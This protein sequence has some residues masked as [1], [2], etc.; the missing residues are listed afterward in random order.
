MTP[1]KV[2]PHCQ[3]PANLKANQCI[4]CGHQ[5]RTPFVPRHDQTQ[6]YNLPNPLPAP[7]PSQITAYRTEQSNPFLI[8]LMWLFVVASVA[9]WI[10][11]RNA[12]IAANIGA[13]MT[14]VFLAV[15]PSSANRSS[16]WIMLALQ[17][18]II[19]MVLGGILKL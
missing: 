10:P 17:S 13:I 7:V 5:F 14:A 1:Y 2:C 9:A 15:S 11:L 8:A 18:V 19:L 12:G 16:G 4:Q 3:H 6:G